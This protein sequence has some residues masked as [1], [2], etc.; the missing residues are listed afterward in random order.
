M[1]RTGKNPSKNQRQDM[2]SLKET[3]TDEWSPSQIWRP[4]KVTNLIWDGQ[5]CCY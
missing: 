1:K 4:Y 5:R 3:P 2:R